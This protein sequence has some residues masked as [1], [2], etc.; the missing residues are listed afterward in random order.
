MSNIYISHT[1]YKGKNLIYASDTN[2][3]RVQV[4]DEL[5]GPA[6]IE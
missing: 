3:D 5:N 2:N 4:F 1:V 6:G